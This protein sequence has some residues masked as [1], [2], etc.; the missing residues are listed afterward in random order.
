MDLINFDD[1]K[2]SELYESFIDGNPSKGYLKVQAFT[3][4][5]TIP[6]ENVEII[7]T[8]NFGDTKVL[9]FRGFTDISGII[10]NIELPSPIGTVDLNKYETPQYTLYD[11]EAVNDFYETI[12]KY[13]LAIYGDTKVL[14]YIKMTPQKE[15]E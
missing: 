13:E 15:G 3:T 7:I 10:D 5:Q 11:M 12:K 2:N 8:K 1:F 4:Y 6:I 9:F 14:Q